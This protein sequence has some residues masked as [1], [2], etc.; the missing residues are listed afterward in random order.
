MFS[1][2]GAN[3]VLHGDIETANAPDGRQT[4]LKRAQSPTETSSSEPPTKKTGV[5]VYVSRDEIAKKEEDS[6]DLHFRVI[7]NDN[8]PEHNIQVHPG[9]Y[10]SIPLSASLALR[11]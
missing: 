8:T 4:S 1:D 9:S 11:C 2:E 6:G 7:Q 3:L 10:P 5:N